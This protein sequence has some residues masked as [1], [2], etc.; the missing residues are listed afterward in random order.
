M[1]E[2]QLMRKEMK[3]MR[4][5]IT[6]LSMEHRDQSNIGGHVTSHTQ[7]GYGNFSPHARTFEHNSYNC[8][9]GNRLVVRNGYNNIFA[10]EFQ[11]MNYDH[12][13]HNYG[14]KD[15]HI[16]HNDSYSYGGY[17]CRRSSQTLGTTSKLLS[18]NNLKLTLLCGTFGSYD[19]VAW[20]QKVE[21]L[22]YSWCKRRRE[23]SIALRTKFGVENH[24]GQ[25]QGQEKEKFIESSMGEKSTK[26]DELSQAQGVLDRKVIHHEK[27]TCTIVKEEKSR[28]EKE[29]VKKKRE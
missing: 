29:R 5:N 11:G 6:N 27:N 3:E 12:Y 14:S 1:Q 25:R 16:E 8:Y 17:N 4:G 28:E 26:V 20:E 13:E 9:V 15:M 23:G 22:F 2:L 21:S 7:W 18:Y 24:E 10:K 19:Y